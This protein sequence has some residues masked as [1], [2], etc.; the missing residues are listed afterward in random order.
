MRR[1]NL[2]PG[3]VLA[4]V[5]AIG[6]LVVSYTMLSTAQTMSQ[7]LQCLAVLWAAGLIGLTGIAW[8]VAAGR[9]HSALPRKEQL[10]ARHKG[11]LKRRMEI[12]ASVANDEKIPYRHFTRE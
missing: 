10:Y 8:T 9:Q 2:M 11:R 5:A 7:F 6:G 4:V 12:W 3:T 1:T